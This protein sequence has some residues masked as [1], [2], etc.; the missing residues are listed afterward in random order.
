[1][2]VIDALRAADSSAFQWK[3]APYE[4]EHDKIPIDVIAGA[5]SFRD[6]IDAGERA[7]QISRRWEGTAAAF[8][9][10]RGQYLLY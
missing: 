10:L 1:M 8:R 5:P 6:A 2:A 3:T 4:Y 7:E 9:T